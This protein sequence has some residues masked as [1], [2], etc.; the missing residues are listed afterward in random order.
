MKLGEH[1]VVRRAVPKDYHPPFARGHSKS[2]VVGG[3]APGLQQV[4]AVTVDQPHYRSGGLRTGGRTGGPAAASGRGQKR[5][6]RCEA[7]PG[8]SEAMRFLV[9]AVLFLAQPLAAQQWNSPDA[10]GVIRQA[11]ERRRSHLADSSLRSYQAVAQ[12]L[13][14]FQAQSSHDDPERP[15]LI[16]AD[17]LRVEVY[18]QAPGRSKQIIS[19]WRDGKFLPTDI[20]YHRDHLAIVTGGFDDRIQLGEGDE[21]LGVLH[22][23]APDGPAAYQYA[24]RDT[25]EVLSQDRNLRVVVLDVKPGDSSQP[26]TVGRLYLDLD[27]GE[28]VRFRFSFTAAAYLDQALEDIS[29]LLENA[30][31]DGYWLPYRQEIV[32]RRR[33]TWFDFPLRS[34]IHGRWQIGDYRLNEPLPPVMFSGPAIAGLMVPDN[35]PGDWELPLEEVVAERVAGDVSPRTLTELKNEVTALVGERALESFRTARPGAGSVSDMIRVNRVHG[36]RLGLGASLPAGPAELRLWAA[37]GTADRRGYLR[38]RISLPTSR[39][40]SISLTGYRDLTDVGDQR[41]ISGLVNSFTS[42]E[43]GR[44]HGDYTLVQGV[45]AALSGF[46]LAGS[47]WEGTFGV[48]KA[49]PVSVEASPSRGSYRPNPAL[50]SGSVALAGVTASRRTAEGSWDIGLEGGLGLDETRSDYLRLDLAF[51]RRWAISASQQ[52]AVR[53]RLG[54]ATAGIAPY[55]SFVMGGRGTLPGEPFRAYGGRRAAL[56]HA[57]WR[58]GVAI[59]QLGLGDFVSTGRTLVVAPFLAAGWSDRPLPGTPWVATPGVRP[60]AGLAVEWLMGL[61]RAEVGVGLRDGGVQL[62]F[63]VSRDWWEVL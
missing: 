46:N 48:E 2:G 7:P 25:I 44:D 49:T 37:Y 3:G 35:D 8:Y 47:E 32:I 60:V 9:P 56:V 14:L 22:P 10:L 43:S 20:H 38:G 12:G 55:R 31:F 19:A 45:E 41:V 51:G 36:L 1:R 53:G 30:L 13:V 16:K 57:E 63:D 52:L 33:V 15:R 5:G 27:S 39:G 18:W 50:G 34:I 58:V 40:H 21:V 17:Q 61:L 24:L 59:P 4:Q 23:L 6:C 29:V 62:L 54:L 26:M 28:L 42:Q 11:I